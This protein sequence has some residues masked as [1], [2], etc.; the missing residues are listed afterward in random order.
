ME[1]D[2]PKFKSP[3]HK[4]VAFLTRSRDGWKAKHLSVKKKLRLT[5]NQ[6]RVVEASR[7][8]WRQRAL[9]AQSELKCKKKQSQT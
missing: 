6:L 8:H 3:I 4:I 9:A 1:T 7:E 2:L 5:E